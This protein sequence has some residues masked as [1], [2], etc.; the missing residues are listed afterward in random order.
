MSWAA[1][2]FSYAARTV[3]AGNAQLPQGPARMA[4]ALQKRARRSR[5]RR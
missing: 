5:W 2:S 4:D 3:P 1:D